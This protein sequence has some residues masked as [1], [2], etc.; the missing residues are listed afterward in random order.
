MIV[1]GFHVRSAA[2]RVSDTTYFWVL[3]I[4]SVNGSP[5]RSGQADA[6]IIRAKGEAEAKAMEVRAD[7]YKQYNQA[8]VLDKMLAASDAGQQE[9]QCGG[10]SMTLAGETGVPEEGPG[11]GYVA[12]QLGRARQWRLPSFCWSRRGCPP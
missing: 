11:A 12:L 8:A 2:E 7:A 1:V 4:Q 3:L 9:L 6:D 10:H 5:L